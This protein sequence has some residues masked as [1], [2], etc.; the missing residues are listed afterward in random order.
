M[1][2]DVGNVRELLLEVALEGLQ[3]LDQLW[4]AGKAASEKHPWA[5]TPAMMVTM[6]HVHL[7]SS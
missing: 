7:L 5:T 4:P 2:E 3:P 6:M 1:R